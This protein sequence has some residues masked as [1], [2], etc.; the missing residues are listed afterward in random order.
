MPERASP[1]VAR[2]SLFSRFFWRQIGDAEALWAVEA[3]S[4]SP[5]A[6]VVA[7]S[8]DGR[9]KVA[10]ASPILA[11]TVPRW[12]RS[13]PRSGGRVQVL[14]AGHASREPQRQDQVP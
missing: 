6:P 8:G 3:V 11:T 7:D 10:A 13:L 4:A 1:V 12:L 2:K 14:P 5:R 9:R